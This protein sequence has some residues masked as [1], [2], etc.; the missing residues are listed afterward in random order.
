MQI[1]KLTM[2]IQKKTKNICINGHDSPHNL[3]SKREREREYIPFGRS[4]V[5]TAGVATRSRGRR[6]IVLLWR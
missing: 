4:D 6:Q 1:I 3:S 2:Q 5:D